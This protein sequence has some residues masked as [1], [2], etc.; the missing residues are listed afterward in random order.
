M[1]F[2]TPRALIV[3]SVLSLI[4]PGH[5]QTTPTVGSA[6]EVVPQID[7]CDVSWDTPGPTA[8]Q[9]MPLGNGDIG[10][11]V[12]VEPSGD[13]NFYIGKTDSFSAN[14][15]DATG[16]MK[17]GGVRLSM[18]PSPLAPGAPF[19][20]TLKLHDGAIE[21]K[22][23]TDAN[24]I[25][26]RLWVDA[27]HPVIRMQA[28]ST[29]PTSYQV[30]LNDWRLDKGDTV[31]PDQSNQVVWYHRNGSN[32][33]PHV[34][35]LTFGGVIKGDGLVTNDATSLKSS[36]P[37][38][39]Q[40]ISVYPLTA[41]T[42]TLDQWTT[43]LQQQV[44]QIDALNLEQTWEA[45]QKWWDDFWHR[46]WIFVSGDQAA[47][48][49]A[50]TTQGYVL[51]RFVTACAG[52]GAYP[53]RFNGTIFVVDDPTKMDKGQPHPVDADYRDWGGGTYWY[54][55]TRAMYWPMLM[56]GDFEMMQP[57]FKMY[58][59]ELNTNIPV[60]KAYYGHDGSY[61]AEQIPFWSGLK[62]VGPQMPAN[63]NDHYFTDILDL[64]MMML[65][66]YEYT[67]DTKFA[68]DTAVP[69]IA[70]GLEFFDKH[71]GLVDGKYFLDPDNAIEMYWKVHDP[72]PDIAGLRAVLPRMIALPDSLVTADQRTQWQ[73]METEVP[74]L[75]TA[76]KNG[77][78]V[79]LPYTGPQTA[80]SRNSEN[81]E[82]Y[83]IYPFRLYG[84]DR[85]DL[86][87][88]VDSFKARKCTA[89]GCWVQDPIQAAMVGLTDVAETYVHYNLTRTDPRLKFIAFWAHG[90][91]YMPDEDN[92]G[93]GEN[94]LQEMLMQVH[95][96]KILLFPAWPKNWDVDFKL[97]APFQTTLQGKVAQGKLVELIVTPPERQADVVNML[98]LPSPVPDSTPT[99]PPAASGDDTSIQNIFSP[100]DQI[101]ALKQTVAGGPNTLADTDDGSGVNHVLDGTIQSKYTN[102]GRDADGFNPP[103]DDTGFVVTPQGGETPVEKIQF[104]TGDDR[105][106]RDP[107]SIT[108]EGSNDPNALAAGGNGFAVIYSGSSGLRND[109]GR[110]QWG[111][112]MT[113]QNQTAYKTYRVLVTET[114]GDSTDMAQYGA[115]KLGN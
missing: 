97:H 5:G 78:K 48:E 81:P 58:Q 108:L 60:V 66:Y 102:R 93:N 101:A 80:H 94:G 34:V 38:T 111:R 1:L 107:M 44:A 79:L 2:S 55:N 10:L 98:G 63:W 77:K 40:L 59:A 21:I 64:G 114:R 17:V 50:E 71:F 86:K 32:A 112:V 25:L 109:P 9:S 90:N 39:S 6:P 22:E 27:N 110:S 83:A 47:K 16:L 29:Q 57:L 45:H 68:Q 42:D 26:I 4:L 19:Q 43:Q 65:D 75:P 61:F 73:R 74:D 56:E 7:A 30:S 11:N 35:N 89:M 84:L 62:Y 37:T 76:I 106:E 46:S 99:D 96:R 72:A 104:S 14:P 23:G 85:P 3:L 113:F 51:Q 82:L 28:S 31:M 12:W 52:R 69:M 67:G 13:V 15:N 41:T 18:N 87:L 24:G 95:G 36:Q 92:G 20:Q 33:N 70:Q 115:V 8:S 49:T 91:D 100:Q 103:G 88:A 54:Q 53:I 105:P